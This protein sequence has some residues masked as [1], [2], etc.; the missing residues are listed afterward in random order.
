[1]IILHAACEKKTKGLAEHGQALF[2]YVPC[3]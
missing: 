1:M 2:L 3:G